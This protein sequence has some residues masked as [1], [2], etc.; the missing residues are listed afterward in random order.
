MEKQ[1]QEKERPAKT[2]RLIALG[3]SKAGK[4][5]LILRYT[6]NS[7]FGNFT[8]TLGTT[9]IAKT[10]TIGVDFKIKK[11]KVKDTPVKME[12]W[13]TGGQERFRT[14][15]RSYY[16]RAM[17]VVLVYDCTDERSFLD[18]RNWVKQIESH[19]HSD[20]VKVL[21]ASKCDLGERKVDTA[22]GKAL[23]EELQMEFFETSAKLNKNVDQA[24]TSLAEQIVTE[25]VEFKELTASISV[26]Q[27]AAFEDKEEKKGCCRN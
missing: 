11:T 4:T 26:K 16:E 21:V 7:F 20:I 27:P 10:T 6:D 17:G 5:S 8:P 24:F 15:A 18:I 3:N 25:E 9:P 1:Q 2:I 14:I 12:I 13:D 23:A 19:A 22:T